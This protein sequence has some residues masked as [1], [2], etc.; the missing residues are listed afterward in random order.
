M[1][2]ALDPSHLC[3]PREADGRVLGRV[4]AV[5]PCIAGRAAEAEEA[6]AVPARIVTAARTAGAFP[7]ASPRW[8]AGEEFGR[9]QVVSG[10]A[11]E[12]RSAH[13]DRLSVRFDRLDDSGGLIT[14]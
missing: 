7:V 9:D 12:H 14:A 13:F 6:R 5:V 1:T 10:G 8:G 2:T 4:R 11:R 3:S